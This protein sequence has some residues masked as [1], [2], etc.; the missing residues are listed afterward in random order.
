MP[1]IDHATYWRRFYDQR[2][3]QV[4]PVDFMR[5]LGYNPRPGMSD[6]ALFSSMLGEIR[7]HLQLAPHHRLLDIACGYGTFTRELAREAALVVGSDLA[8]GMLQRGRTLAPVPDPLRGVV[9][10]RGERQP[11]A[12]RSFDRILCFSMLLYLPPAGVRRLVAEILRLLR[13]GGRAVLGDVLHPRRLHYECSY[14]GRVPASLHFPLRQVLRCKRALDIWRGRVVYQAYAPE[15]FAP[16]VP[17]GAEL[18]V[19]AKADGRHNNAARY[20]LV[21]QLPA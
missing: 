17:P 5:V 14:I 16:L 2:A 13:P 9:Q 4:P 21:I 15:F 20:D 11:F 8:I 12:D 18:E 19:G 1:T 6:E 10:A 3:D 7:Q